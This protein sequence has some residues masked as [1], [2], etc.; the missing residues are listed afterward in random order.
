MTGPAGAAWPRTHWLADLLSATLGALPERA[1]GRDVEKVGYAIPDGPDAHMFYVLGGDGIRY[2]VT[3]ARD[4]D[5]SP[6][7]RPGREPI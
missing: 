7:A 3:V 1:A 2:R 5:Q 6:P 4:D